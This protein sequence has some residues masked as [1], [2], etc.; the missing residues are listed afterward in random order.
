MAK[1][2]KSHGFPIKPQITVVRVTPTTCGCRAAQK[3]KSFPLTVFSLSIRPETCVWM[4]VRNDSQTGPWGSPSQQR[5]MGK[6]L[7]NPP[8]QPQVARLG[9]LRPQRR[10]EHKTIVIVCSAFTPK[11]K[12]ARRG[13]SRCNVI[14]ALQGLLLIEKIHQT[15]RERDQTAWSLLGNSFNLYQIIPPQLPCS[16]HSQ[17]G[18]TWDGY[19][20]TKL[21]HFKKGSCPIFSSAKLQLSHRTVS[22]C[23]KR[24]R[25]RY[26]PRNDNRPNTVWNGWEKYCRGGDC[27]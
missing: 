7:H 20:E 23:D 21:C 25:N 24:Q 6:R 10:A 5:C 4:P 11:N 8:K 22:Y 18:A 16:L 1:S 2:Q 27:Y 9:H 19:N 17:A 12:R 3:A 15:S 26:E 14:H 13:K